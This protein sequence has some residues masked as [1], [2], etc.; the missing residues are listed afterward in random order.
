M[1]GFLPKPLRIDELSAGLT[2]YARIQVN[3]IE[4]IAL[5]TTSV[6]SKTQTAPENFAAY[7]IPDVL[8]DWS[9]LDQFK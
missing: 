7:A 9:H 5:S 8:I 6:V 2:Q 3:D 4:S 1:I